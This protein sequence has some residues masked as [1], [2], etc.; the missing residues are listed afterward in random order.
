MRPATRARTGCMPTMRPAPRPNGVMPTISRHSDDAS[1]QPGRTGCMPTIRPGN[2][3]ERACCRCLTHTRDRS[4]RVASLLQRR[5][6]RGARNLVANA[7]S[8]PPKTELCGP[9]DTPRRSV[10]AL[11]VNGVY[12][13]DASRHSGCMPT[14]RPATQG[15]RACCRCLTHTRDRSPRVASLLQRRVSRGARRASATSSDRSWIPACA[16]MMP[17]IR[18]ATQ[19]EGLPLPHRAGMTVVQGLRTRESIPDQGAPLRHR[20]KSVRRGTQGERIVWRQPDPNQDFDYRS[21][22]MPTKKGNLQGWQRSSQ[23]L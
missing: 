9:F 5:V 10:G 21:T 8:T 17:T 6:S 23:Q 2:Q 18:P 20:E 14:I 22:V 11:R 7:M 16:G 1:R 13:D 19:G 15:G 4:P 3:G 12:A